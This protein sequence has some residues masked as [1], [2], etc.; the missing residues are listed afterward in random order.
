MRMTFYGAAR[1]VTGSKIL[2]ET[3]GVKLLVDC[4]LHQ[5]TKENKE[6][7][8]LPFPFDPKKLDHVILT[9]AHI[10][11][12]GLI[13]KLVKDG[14]SGN[15]ICTHG[16]A[17]LCDIMLKDSAHIQ[18]QENEWDNKR[19]KRKGLPERDPLYNVEDAERAMTVFA[20]KEYDQKIDLGRGIS[21]IFS[22][23]AHI[24][25]S[26]HVL[27]ESENMRIGL[28]GDIGGSVSPVL[29][30]PSPFKSADY[31]IMESTYGDRNKEPIENSLN[32]LSQ[33]INDSLMSGGKI[34]IP[35]F[36]VGRTQLMLYYMNELHKSGKLNL[37]KTFLDSPLSIKA[38]EIY[39]RLIK[40]HPEYF[41][42]TIRNLSKEG[43]SPF[44]FPTLTLTS[45][46][47]ESMT[48][49]EY[50]RPAI[51]ISSAGMCNAG[52]I[53]HHLKRHI[54]NPNSTVLFVGYQAEG[55]LGRQI[56]EGEKQ[57]SILGEMFEVHASIHVLNSFSAH[58]DRAKL[59]DFVNSMTDK[60]KKIFINHGESKAAESLAG[61]IG[62]STGIECIIP[63]YKSAYEL[64]P[65]GVT[66][67][68]E[69]VAV[70]TEEDDNRIYADSIEIEKLMDGFIEK[71]GKFISHDET[72]GDL[73]KRFEGLSKRSLRSLIL[74]KRLS[75]YLGDNVFE[76]FS[77]LME[78]EDLVDTKLEQKIK[79]FK[80]EYFLSMDPIIE[81]FIKKISEVLKP[82]Q[83]FIKH[84]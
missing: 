50:D 18:I 80:K 33:I 29:N 8:F 38:T 5:G 41:S 78:S 12:S 23:A 14:F 52:R 45:T 48:I 26:A 27:L 53:L 75:D 24:V 71:L 55:T 68:Q 54:W 73:S 62:K 70:W 19:R 84:D 39:S 15:I 34:L 81:D 44:D 60:P 51:I 82:T 4:G 20:P 25:G 58:A 59:L 57:V 47:E 16:T 32:K 17:S 35:S 43:V 63:E 65:E 7:N 74:L 64:S 37:I 49:N 31:V 6:L 10:D 56:L 2:I 46:V 1:E 36:A 22:D 9:H 72:Y 76:N 11:H 28:S 67:L 30:T 69:E 61:E 66:A 79:E 77:K 83:S 40:D 3:K 42:D 13:P 21:V